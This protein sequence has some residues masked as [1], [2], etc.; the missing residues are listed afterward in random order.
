MLNEKEK[1]IIGVNRSSQPFHLEVEN[2]YDDV[3]NNET[4]KEEYILNPNEG[5]L[6]VKKI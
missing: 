1:V 3:L 6:L 4:V 2:V 5:C